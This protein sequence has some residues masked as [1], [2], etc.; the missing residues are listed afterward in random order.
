MYEAEIAR[1]VAALD[2]Y[3]PSWRDGIDV[4]TVDQGRVTRCVAGQVTGVT[5][6][7]PLDV[8]PNEGLVWSD[9]LVQLGAPEARAGGY[10]DD[11]Q[12]A[13][14]VEHGFEASADENHRRDYDGLTAAWRAY[15]RGELTLPSVEEPA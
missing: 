4:D 14:A 6:C 2:R 3:D 1:G 10:T 7:C 5:D 8:D 13:W 15:L 12:A 9:A 11:A